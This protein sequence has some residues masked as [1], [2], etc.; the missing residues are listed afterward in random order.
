M[1]KENI[2]HNF[3]KKHDIEP[4]DIKK[5]DIQRGSYKYIFEVSSKDSFKVYR[6]NYKKDINEEGFNIYF[7]HE[8]KNKFSCTLKKLKN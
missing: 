5:M 8:T 6:L 4:I 2:I 3:L 7:M 1:K